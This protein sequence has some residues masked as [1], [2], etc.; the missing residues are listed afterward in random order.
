M[1]PQQLTRRRAV[2]HHDSC[3]VMAGRQACC[4]RRG[5]RGFEGRE[6]GGGRWNRLGPAEVEG[7]HHL[8]GR[9]LIRFLPSHYASNLS[10]SVIVDALNACFGLNVSPPNTNA[11]CVI[12]DM[13]CE[14]SDDVHPAGFVNGDAGLRSVH[15]AFGKPGEALSFSAM[16][17]CTLASTRLSL[18]AL[19]G[20][21]TEE[22][23]RCSYALSKLAGNAPLAQNLSGAYS[24]NEWYVVSVVTY[25][26]LLF[27][28]PREAH[29]TECSAAGLHRVFG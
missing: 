12:K 14:L 4:L 7:H 28:L 26:L 15:H 20:A 22:S 6:G 13:P 19:R 29:S 18:S 23:P 1:G 24:P 2:L 16:H 3:H 8:I 11:P 9:C 25:D 17:G 27:L 21:A 10:S 5:C